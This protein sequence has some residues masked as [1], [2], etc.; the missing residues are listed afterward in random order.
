MTTYV[1]EMRG[2]HRNKTPD[3]RKYPTE[4]TRSL[5]EELSGQPFEYQ[6]ILP[7]F[8][9]YLPDTQAS[10]VSPE[11]RALA[12]FCLLIFNSHEFVYSY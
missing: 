1:T 11:T 4:I 6:E 2:Y 8:E 10:D 12:D 7:V 5:V 9:D 3:K